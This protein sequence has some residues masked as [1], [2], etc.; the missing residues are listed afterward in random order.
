MSLIQFNKVVKSEMEK[1]EKRG[2]RKAGIPNR[3]TSEM[4][5]II[6]DLLSNQYGRFLTKLNEIEE[7][8]DYCN[9]YLK[10]M[11]FVVPKPRAITIENMEVERKRVADLFPE[12]L[13]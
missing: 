11:S 1:R 12:D 6:S 13:E 2:G 10:A 4:K 3:V 9:I 7:P 8:V 5:D